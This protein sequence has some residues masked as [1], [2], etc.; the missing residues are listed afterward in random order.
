M[1]NI[2]I[3]SDMLTDICQGF[4]RNR[5]GL[6]EAMEVYSNTASYRPNHNY[7]CFFAENSLGP[8]FSFDIEQQSGRLINSFDFCQP[9]TDV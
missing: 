8:G 2:M 9:I 5:I 7:M 4:Q 6:A 3:V 1:L